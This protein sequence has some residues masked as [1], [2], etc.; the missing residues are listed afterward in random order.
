M[1]LLLELNYL[2]LNDLTRIACGVDYT[3]NGE[4]INIARQFHITTYR[5]WRGH[6]LSKSW[7]PLA[8][9]DSGCGVETTLEK[10]SSTQHS[11]QPKLTLV[12]LR[13]V[14]ITS[15]SMRFPTI[16]MKLQR[17]SSLCLLRLG[18]EVLD[19]KARAAGLWRHA[20]IMSSRDELRIFTP[21]SHQNGVPVTY[22]QNSELLFPAS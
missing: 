12:L 22:P 20:G 6:R 9:G 3:G 18:E 19:R 7:E 15:V 17:K 1:Q 11:S 16:Q 13:E 5:S 2:D 14:F 8:E 4:R 10:P 21:F